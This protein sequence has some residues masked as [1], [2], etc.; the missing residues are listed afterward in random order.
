MEPKHSWLVSACQK[1]K[2]LN[3]LS[4]LA[5]IVLSELVFIFPL[6]SHM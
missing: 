3:S 1:A 6:R 2:V 5:F 4:L